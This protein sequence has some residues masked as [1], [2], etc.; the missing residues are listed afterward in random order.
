MAEHNN[1][2]LQ[3][4]KMFDGDYTGL[5]NNN[6]Y[7]RNVN[8]AP[9][10][11]M[12]PNV[13]TYNAPMPQQPT[14]PSYALP[15]YQ[16][17]TFLDRFLRRENPNNQRIR[18][19]RNKAMI[20]DYMYNQLDNNTDRLLFALDPNSY[21]DKAQSASFESANKEG[22]I[23][24]RR[25]ILNKATGR[26]HYVDGAQEPVFKD[27][28]EVKGEEKEL[29]TIQLFEAYKKAEE[30][31][32]TDLAKYLLRELEAIGN[33]DS[34]SI[35]ITTNE[36]G[37]Q[38]IRYN[39][40]GL[41]QTGAQSQKTDG[42]IIQ[43][44]GEGGLYHLPGDFENYFSNE[45]YQREFELSF[46]KD[47]T[48]AR[49]IQAIA[50]D[51]DII[52]LDYVTTIP[53]A[54]ERYGANVVLKMGGEDLF[55]ALYSAED[56]DKYERSVALIQ[57]QT[58]QLNAYIKEI[59]GAQMSEKEVTRLVQALANVG[60][61]GDL[62]RVFGAGDNPVAFRIKFDI[63]MKHIQEARARRYFYIKNKQIMDRIKEDY[64]MIGGLDYAMMSK[65]MAQ[66]VYEIANPSR[67]FYEQ[68]FTD[69]Q[70][71]KYNERINYATNADFYFDDYRMRDLLDTVQDVNLERN[72]KS[73]YDQE[74]I[75]RQ[76]FMTIISD[77]D[78]P[79]YEKYYNVELDAQLR[80]I[81]DRNE[82]FG[83]GRNELSLKQR[84]MFSNYEPWTNRERT[85]GNYFSIDMDAL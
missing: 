62:G 55:N 77:P 43:K 78:H 3:F 27:G 79:S 15:E 24:G 58:A 9:Q 57:N 84:R 35:T 20:Q 51:L 19:A 13:N 73:F 18:E 42:L 8:N 1:T 38:T 25:Y 36:D 75:T 68:E 29:K 23:N 17:P 4:N 2:K 82:M 65:Y 45:K 30:E 26:Y 70:G 53:G 10:S 63:V 21:I 74:G 69:E 48:Q 37:T 54:L 22:M 85:D 52:G 5:L 67:G 31:G 80:A 66:D 14:K 41:N 34:P 81:Q 39:E 46:Q 76:E 59:T 32:N 72:R 49:K 12:S 40:D 16:N 56:R 6:I 83:L 60:V 44:S 50:D 11:L 64:S 71:N 28:L 33:S 61:T 7:A 47:Q